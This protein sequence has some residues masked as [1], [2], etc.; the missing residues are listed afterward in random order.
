MVHVLESTLKVILYLTPAE[1][2]IHYVSI[3][4]YSLSKGGFIKD[5]YC[6]LVQYK[7]G[8]GGGPSM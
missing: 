7:S 2:P 1:G 4:E 5:E 6:P 3:F 8:P